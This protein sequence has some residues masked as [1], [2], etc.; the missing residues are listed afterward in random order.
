MP[1]VL[2][3]SRKKKLSESCIAFCLNIFMPTVKQNRKIEYMYVIFYAKET[4]HSVHML[5]WDCSINYFAKLK[6]LDEVI[7]KK[8]HSQSAVKAAARPNPFFSE[9]EPKSQIAP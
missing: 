1:K 4:L 6:T 2:V 8:R 9:A 3:F 5:L 7:F